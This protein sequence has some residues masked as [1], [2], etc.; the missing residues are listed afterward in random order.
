MEQIGFFD[1][2]KQK[3]TDWKW[4]FKDYPI[5]FLNNALHSEKS[6]GDVSFRICEKRTGFNDRIVWDEDIL[7]VITAKCNIMRG[8]EK[9]KI[10]D[11]D[12]I[13]CQTF[14]EDYNFLNQNIGY[15]CG[16]SVPPL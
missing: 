3:S 6:I 11:I 10:T 15:I 9:T 4:S 13:H 2:Q 7:P 5:Y 1:N 14:P 8:E 16:M 12:I